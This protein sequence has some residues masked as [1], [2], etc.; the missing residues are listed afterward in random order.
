[1]YLRKQDYLL[2]HMTIDKDTEIY[3]QNRIINKSVNHHELSPVKLRNERLNQLKKDNL[4]GP[5]I[6]KVFEL[7][8][9][10][11]TI[12][13]FKLRIYIPFSIKKLREY[14][15]ILFFHGG[16]FEWKS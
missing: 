8:V 16:G 10:E 11:T 7:V 4:V 14:P 13:E 6:N 9:G 2:F 5:D 3:L 12:S 1:M 15:V